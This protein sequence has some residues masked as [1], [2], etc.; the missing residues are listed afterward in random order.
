MA[1]PYVREFGEWT[2][3]EASLDGSEVALVLMIAWKLARKALWFMVSSFAP[4]YMKA[5]L[6]PFD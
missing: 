2:G 4:R 5:S 6:D 3:T 1:G